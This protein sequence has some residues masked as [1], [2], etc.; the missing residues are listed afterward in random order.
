VPI[1]IL[2]FGRTDTDKLRPAV[3]IP[4]STLTPLSWL[5][6]KFPRLTGRWKLDVGDLRNS[7]IKRIGK[8]RGGIQSKLYKL[9][10]GVQ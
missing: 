10:H 5:V 6:G 1:S 8:L 9:Q 3:L 4:F 7:E 2:G